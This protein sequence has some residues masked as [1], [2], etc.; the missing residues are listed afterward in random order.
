MFSRHFP[1][2]RNGKFITLDSSQECHSFTSHNC[3]IVL[4]RKLS[5]IVK[6][7]CEGS[8]ADGIN[9]R[10]SQVFPSTGN[11][12]IGKF[13]WACVMMS[14]KRKFAALDGEGSSSVERLCPCCHQRFLA[15]KCIRKLCAECCRKKRR[16]DR[17]KGPCEGHGSKRQKGKQKKSQEKEER[18]RE[19]KL[20]VTKEKRK[21][22]EKQN[23]LHTEEKQLVQEKKLWAQKKKKIIK[24]FVEDELDSRDGGRKLVAT[25]TIASNL[26]GYR[27]NQYGVFFT[28]D[29]SRREKCCSSSD[30]TNE[31]PKRR[32]KTEKR[33]SK[34]IDGLEDSV[35]D[36]VVEQA[37][38]LRKL[39]K[40]LRSLRK[41]L[42]EKEE[43]EKQKEK[44][45]PSAPLCILCEE[46]V[47]NLALIPCGHIFCSNTAC[48]ASS[49]SLCPLCKAPVA[50]TQKVYYG[51]YI[52]DEAVQNIPT[53]PVLPPRI[54]F[55]NPRHIFFN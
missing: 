22:K 3:R 37:K 23:Q 5:Q 29:G 49:A 42:A 21:L 2:P 15:V 40:K 48:S 31:K 25:K 4:L 53:P 30:E 12:F 1:F 45:S 10:H 33:K 9:S 51:M 41:E 32:E 39:K 36:L 44:A 34:Q 27:G 38:K 18:K 11:T 16:H 46:H 6:C 24:L 55:N 17:L 19:N 28:G 7:V 13:I 52:A 47:S 20:H 54:G 50:A 43:K 26:A 14:G 8:L 35:K